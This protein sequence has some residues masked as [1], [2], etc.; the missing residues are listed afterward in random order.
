VKPAAPSIAIAASVVVFPMSINNLNIFMELLVR[1]HHAHQG[2]AKFT[3]TRCI[4]MS[5]LLQENMPTL[6]HI[7]LTSVQNC[8]NVLSCHMF[9]VLCPTGGCVC[10]C[11]Y[12][13]MIGSKLRAEC[14]ETK[15][16]D[17]N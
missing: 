6:S 11:I 2:F 5:K 12:R 3:F 9:W 7:V 1:H 14:R 16:F 8:D 15:N 10:A 4:V 17:I 13:L